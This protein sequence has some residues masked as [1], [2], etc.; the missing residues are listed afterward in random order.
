MEHW[1]IPL[2]IISGIV[3]AIGGYFSF[4]YKPYCMFKNPE[5]E[6]AMNLRRKKLREKE[7]GVKDEMTSE[8]KQQYAIYAHIYRMDYF[9]RNYIFGSSA[10]LHLVLLAILLYSPLDWIHKMPLYAISGLLLLV[11]FQGFSLGGENLFCISNSNKKELMV[12]ESYYKQRQNSQLDNDDKKNIKNAKFQ[13]MIYKWRQNFLF[14]GLWV[15]LFASIM[16]VL[17]I[18]IN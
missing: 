14:I 15:H 7:L 18:V 10:L 2:Y 13:I 11:G 3:M 9:W 5:R 6:I 4:K 12:P 8:E 1:V 16:H 17:L